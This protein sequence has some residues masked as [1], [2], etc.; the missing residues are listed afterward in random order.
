VQ[1]QEELILKPPPPKEG[2]EEGPPE[3]K[4]GVMSLL[5]GV[6]KFN[7][8]LKRVVLAN[9]GLDDAAGAF[10]ATALLENKTLENMD[11]SGNPSLG[12]TGITGIAMAARDHPA[13]VGMK[14]D[15]K[16]LPIAQLRGS[17][18]SDG[19][20]DFA[21]ALFGPLS[22]HAIGTIVTQNRTLLNLNLKSN[23]LGADGVSAVVGGLSDA[24]LKALDVTRNALGGAQAGASDLKGLTESI[25]RNLGSL[26]DL[27]M[28]ENDLDCPAASLAPLCK[29]RYLRI[30]SWEK[31]RLTE[32]PP[33]IGTMLSLRKLILHSNQLMDLPGSLCLL[34]S[35]ETLDIHKNLIPSL[36]AGIGNMKALQKLDLSENK[37]A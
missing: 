36:P 17:K 33:L 37:L 24:P 22:G 20:I 16:E 21:D 19:S 7:E 11:I 1:D 26:L 2:E 25:C 14:V 30:L 32:L 13:L 35:L 27:R 29:L 28:D 5:A 3:T 6:L 15:G 34:T 9:V 23:K 10:F 18:G 8:S 4:P 12:A 31:N